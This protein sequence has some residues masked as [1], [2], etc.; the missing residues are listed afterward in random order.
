MIGNVPEKQKSGTFIAPKICNKSLAPYTCVLPG[1][2]PNVSSLSCR[3]M[4]TSTTPKTG[5]NYSLIS[6][7]KITQQT[8]KCQR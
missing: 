7:L 3:V 8:A 5:V 1:C 4:T 2:R 6:K